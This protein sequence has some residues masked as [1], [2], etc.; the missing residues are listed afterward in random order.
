MH[1][2][3]TLDQFHDLLATQQQFVIFKHSTRCSISSNACREVYQ[4]INALGLE[5]VYLLDVLTTGDLKHKLAT[6]INI[7]HESPQLLIFDQGKLTAHASH[8]T[9]SHGWIIN[10]LQ[11]RHDTRKSSDKQPS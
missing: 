9:I 6:E 11:G 10:Q 1:S 7:K 3:T 5:N 8:G 2:L 4:A